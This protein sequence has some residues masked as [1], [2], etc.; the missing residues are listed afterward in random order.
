M[1]LPL[2]AALAALV[3]L[4]LRADPPRVVADIAPVHALAAQVMEG[5]GQPDLLLTPG[6]SPHEAALKP[7]QA[8]MLQ[9]AGLV[10]WI[11]P[12]L[13]PWLGPAL[14]NLA[15]GGNRLALL[16]APQ[17]LRLTYRDLGAGDH[18][19]D[20]A[21]TD[22]HAWLDPRNGAIWLGLIADRL[23]TLD[24][25]NGD[26]Y[27]ANARAGQ[28]RLAALESDLAARLASARDRPF[29]AQHDAYQYFEARFGLTLA[30]TVAPG[31]ATD[32]GPARLARLRAIV[33]E[34]GIT[35]A[36]REPQ[37]SDGT[38]RAATEGS[39]ITLSVLDPLG[40]AL[41]PGPDF[42]AALLRDIATTI[43]DCT[44]K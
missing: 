44:D 2:I 39:G 10:I 12:E 36:F 3:A 38:L 28:A 19:H 20:H 40:S 6:P 17:T 5:M 21:G 35:C 27:R 9:E 15:P 30:A 42:Y 32:A 13:T 8:R 22:P 43:A 18:D 16:D 31:A 11:G 24:P 41:T 33:A 34:Q 26:R 37:F 1:R 25:A 4:P 23:A 7:S 29:I 14:D